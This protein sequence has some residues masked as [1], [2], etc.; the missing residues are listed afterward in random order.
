M[1]FRGAMLA[2]VSA[3]LSSIAMAQTGT[4]E[5]KT[6]CRSDVRKFC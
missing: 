4:R 3:C 5:E 1:M 2:G 6:A